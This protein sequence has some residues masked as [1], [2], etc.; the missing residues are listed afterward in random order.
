VSV[1]P[2]YTHDHVEGTS[3][4]RKRKPLE[5]NKQLLKAC[6]SFSNR[7]LAKQLIRMYHP[8]DLQHFLQLHTFPLQRDAPARD[9]E[10]C[11][12]AY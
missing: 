9:A 7:G 8:V 11:E 5:T 4:L 12:N 2:L 1:P 3:G 10:P 6:A